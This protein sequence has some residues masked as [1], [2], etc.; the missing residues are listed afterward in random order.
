MSRDSI[1]IQNYNINTICTLRQKK[2]NNLYFN[3]VMKL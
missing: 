2:V 3:Q 1:I